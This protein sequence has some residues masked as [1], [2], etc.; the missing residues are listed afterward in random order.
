MVSKLLVIVIALVILAAISIVSVQNKNKITDS[1]GLSYQQFCVKN[2]D[3]WMVMEPWRDGKKIGGEACSGCMIAGNHFC[4]EEEYTGYIKSSQR[5]KAMDMGNMDHMVDSAMT[6]SAGYNKTADIGMYIA[7][8]NKPKA[9]SAKE[10]LLSFTIKDKMSGKEITDLEIEHEKPMHLILIRKDMK[11]FDHMHPVLKNNSWE[12]NY[13]FLAS[14]EYRL[15][16]G[17]KKEMDHII[18]FDLAVSGNTSLQEKDSLGG[19]KVEIKKPN[20]ILVGEKTDFE[21]DVQDP[22]GNPINIKEMFL[23]AA[24]HMIAIN[25]TLE[26]FVHTHDMKMDSDNKLSFSLTF[27]K[28]GKHKLWVQFIADGKERVAEFEIVVDKDSS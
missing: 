6:A 23:G 25:E 14:G 9:E 18:D 1:T 16:I 7:E 8:F 19:I 11:Y 4:S 20:K 28:T 17:F 26:E 27:S 3:Q 5:T 12:T 10:S 13:N 24:G 21:F 2:G 15:W 22:T